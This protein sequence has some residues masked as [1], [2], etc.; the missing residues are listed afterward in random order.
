MASFAPIRG[1]Q[2]Q[3]NA[4]PLVDG[5]FLIETDQGDQNKIYVDTDINGT[6][7]R[8][9]A[10]GGGHEILPTPA[11]SIPDTGTGSVVEA[12]NNSSSTSENV[13]SLYTIQRWSNGQ[14][15]RFIYTGTVSE[16]GIGTWVDNP[17][18]VEAT[19]SGTENPSTEQWYEVSNNEYVL[20]SDTSVVSGKT[21]YTS[22][23]TETGWWLVSELQTIDVASSDEIKI[24]FLFDPTINE[25]V[26]LGGYILDTNTGKICLKFGANISSAAAASVKVAVDIT[27]LR[28]EYPTS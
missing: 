15:K 14:T 23:P 18:A 22:V 7:T 6:V 11:S 21:Y 13:P 2:A 4:T 10:G 9:M 17:E 20:T 26:A 19:P 3:I 25:P 12:V 1:T 16:S 27:Y 5:Q 28:N 8:S 24:E